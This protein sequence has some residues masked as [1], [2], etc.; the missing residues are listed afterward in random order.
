VSFKKT[1]KQK[2]AITL[3]SSLARYCMLYGGSRSGKT[4]IAIYAII[5]RA[6]KIKSRHVILRL[7]FNH[8]KTSIWLDTLPKVFSLA[9]PQLPYEKNKSDYYVTLPNGSEIWIGGLDDEKRVEKILGKEYSTLYFNECSQ[10]PYASIQVAMTRL[11]EK[12]DL[13]KKAYFDENP[14]SK[15]HWSYKLFIQKKNPIDNTQVDPEKYASIL[16]NPEDNKEN[17]DESYISEVLSSLSEK[18]KQRFLKGEFVTDDDGLAYYEFKRERNV[19]RIDSKLLVGSTLIGMDFNVNPMTA[20]IA[21]QVNGII[22][23]YQ[24]AFLNNSDTPKMISYL[25]SKGHSGA[26]VYPDSTGRNRKT[27]GMSD[28]QFLNN[29]GFKIQG[30]T[31]PFVVDRINNINLLLK[32]GKLIID[33]SCE[34]LIHDLESVSWKD[35]DLDKKTDTMLTHISDALGYLCWAVDCFVYKNLKSEIIKF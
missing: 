5:V 34:K 9:F 24:E 11:A 6:S 30:V 16:M 25:Q 31:N 13:T 33:E 21:K 7:N 29:A 22:Y 3:L 35:N 12:N 19:Q 4:F 17:I 27:S 32:E 28:F 8:A 10:I 15:R 23:V 26:L 2:Q 18:Q 14:P 20:V 1:N